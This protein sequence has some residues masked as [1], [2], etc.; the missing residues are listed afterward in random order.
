[1]DHLKAQLNNYLFLEFGVEGD[2]SRVSATWPFDLRELAA[3]PDLTVFE[4]HDDEAYFALAGE[5]LN[6]LPQAGMTVDDLIVQNDDARWIRVRAP[7]SLSE[8]RLG[9]PSVPSGLERSQHLQDLGRATLPDGVVEILEGL[10][11][12]REHATWLSS[13]ELEMKRR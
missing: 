6:F 7:V 12:K 11:L 4:F 10:F 2:E 5:S 8:A 9:D 13:G 3:T 1:M